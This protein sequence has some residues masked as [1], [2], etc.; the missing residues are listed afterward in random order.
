MG[1]E[2]FSNDATS[3]ILGFDYQKLV[4]LKMCLDAKPNETI[5]IECRGDVADES[6]TTEVKHHSGKHNLTS[7][8]VDVWKTLTN[9][10][11]QYNIAKH[12]SSL[13][14]LTT[15]AIPKTSIF[16]NWNKLN[17]AEKYSSLINHSPSDS[18]KDYQNAV[19]NCDKKMMKSILDR[20]IIVSDQPRIKAK[21]DELIM[22]PA[23]IIVPENFRDQAVETLYGYIT[24][25][26]I[27]NH[28]EWKIEINDFRKDI[29]HTLSRF[30][31]SKTPFHFVEEPNYP[32]GLRKDDFNF[33][34]KMKEIKLKKRN[35]E[36]AVNDYFR[37]QESQIHLLSKSPTLIHNLEIYDA[38]VCR[39]LEDEKL[40]SSYTLCIEDIGTEAADEKSRDLYFRCHAKPHLQ[41]VGVS[42]T[43]KYYRDGRIQFVANEKPFVWK[44]GKDDI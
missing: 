12:F 8:S 29:E 40:A 37:A 13:V 20:F 18:I 34:K 28:D 31:T 35:Q 30:V 44:Y 21:W 42:D 38:T 19:K 41:I 32:T 43:Q 9:H 22:H 16:C 11:E 39:E 27:D 24:K 10:I 2:N 25:A 17:F 6:S 15:S 7:N 33:I 36:N 3:K 1:D 26:A 5:W 4:A 14:L 23:L